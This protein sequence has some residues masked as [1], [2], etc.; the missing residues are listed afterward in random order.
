M[1]TKLIG[2]VL[3]MGATAHDAKVDE[4]SWMAGS[5]TC[6]KWG[7]TYEEHWSTPA[8]GLLMGFSRLLVPGKSAFKE[9]S[10]IEDT[11][12]G[13]V[14]Y[15]EVNPKR[16]KAGNITAFPIKELTKEKVV[17]ENLKH[18][19]PQR[20]IYTKKSDGTI[21]ARIEGEG[22]SAEDFIFKKAKH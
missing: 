3:A 14:L 9:I 21:N 17:F 13:M 12:D 5:W 19:F 16:E 6:Q 4:L 18:D 1:V 7:G 10:R 15:V 22:Q 2:L 8:G 11:E 20:V